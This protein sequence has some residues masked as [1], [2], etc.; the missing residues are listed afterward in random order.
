MTS[1]VYPRG[2]RGK[3]NW[4]DPTPTGMTVSERNAHF[5]TRPV[6][7]DDLLREPLPAVQDG[8]W[9]HDDLLLAHAYPPRLLS[10]PRKPRCARRMNGPTIATPE[11]ESHC[12]VPDQ[13]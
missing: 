5:R 12:L 1:G 3:G 11:E 9:R 6:T 2:K 8:E 7:A 13:L 10:V 4:R